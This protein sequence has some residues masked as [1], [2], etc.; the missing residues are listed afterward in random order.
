MS[1]EVSI[2]SINRS[3][4]IQ[5]LVLLRAASA[6]QVPQ[7]DYITT[8]WQT[9]Q[10][11]PENSATAMVQTADGYLWFGTFNGLVR[12]DGIR[13]TVFNTSTTTALPHDGIVNLHLNQ[14]GAL[15]VSTLGGMARLD[16]GVWSRFGASEGFTGDYARFF[17]E[18]PGLA[19]T[20]RDAGR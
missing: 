19:G 13:F 1:N 12:F 5:L 4:A 9:E 7:Q 11:L 10:G 8:Q 2:Q 14:R 3:R 15:W 6:G 18:G 17:A 20:D 16:H